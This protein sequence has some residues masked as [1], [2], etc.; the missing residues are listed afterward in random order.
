[1]IEPRELFFGCGSTVAAAHSLKASKKMI[2]PSGKH[3]KYWARE[4]EGGAGEL[5]VVIRPFKWTDPNTRT[6]G[7]LHLSVTPVAF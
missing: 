4:G 2:I 3:R 7:S 1:M 6:R 5:E